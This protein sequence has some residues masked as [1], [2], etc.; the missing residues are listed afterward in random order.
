[1]NKLKQAGLAIVLA[2]VAASAAT[3]GVPSA[4]TLTCQTKESIVVVQDKVSNLVL[5]EISNIGDKFEQSS[6]IIKKNGVTMIDEGLVV[7]T[8]T[9]NK[10]TDILMKFIDDGIE[11]AVKLKVDFANSTFTQEGVKTGCDIS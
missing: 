8:K 1:M 3:A 10:V 11:Q 9:K 5:T 6:E 2:S 4:Q 7:I